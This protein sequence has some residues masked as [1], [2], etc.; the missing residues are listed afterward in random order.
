MV[1]Q[2]QARR[3]RR[4]ADTPA[5]WSTSPPPRPPRVPPGNVISTNPPAGTEPGQ[6]LGGA[7]GGVDREAV[8]TIPSL[9]G[10]TRPAR[11]ARSWARLQLI[12]GSQVSEPSTSV[13]AGE[14]T[15]TAPP[16]G[17]S[18]PIGSSVTV[19]VSSGRAPGDRARPGQRH[20]GPGAAPPSRRPAWPGTSAPPPIDQREPERRGH[21]EPDPAA[22]ATVDKGST[23]NV[24]DR[25]V[26]SATPRPPP[27]AR[28]DHDRRRR[29]RW[30]ATYAAGDAR[31]FQPPT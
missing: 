4:P 7:A 16:A 31:R 6:G 24:V 17:T 12:V 2:P 23:V 25:A 11:R 27:P 8:V 22:E 14:V 5:S 15:R 3:P 28:A 10:Q 21:A 9:V 20:P 26:H 1:G 29:P 19:F 18:V 30:P 13:P